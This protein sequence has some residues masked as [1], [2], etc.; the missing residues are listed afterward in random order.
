[1]LIGLFI[2]LTLIGHLLF[3]VHCAVAGGASFFV[4]RSSNLIRKMVRY[5]GKPEGQF[6]RRVQMNS[7]KMGGQ[8]KCSKA[9]LFGKVKVLQ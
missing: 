6:K 7:V 5:C 9:S 4:S 2:P 3:G 8:C 1:M